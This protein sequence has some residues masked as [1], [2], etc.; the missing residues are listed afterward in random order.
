MNRRGNVVNCVVWYG[1]V[2]PY[3]ANV[4]YGTLMVVC[5]FV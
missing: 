2:L 3:I 5:R 4:L 1:D